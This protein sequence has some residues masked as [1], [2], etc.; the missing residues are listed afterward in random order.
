MADDDRPVLVLTA[1]EDTTADDV[2]GELNARSVPVVRLDPGDFPVGVTLAAQV[3]GD[4]GTRG[5]LRTATRTVDLSRVRAVYRRRP[6]PYRFDHLPARDAEFA[7]AQARHGLGGVLDAL[8][9]A[10]YVNHPRRNAAADYKPVQLA[11]AAELGFPVPAT[12]I[13][14][15]PRTARDFTEDHGPVVYKPLRGTSYRDDDG[16][17]LTIWTQEVNPA[18]LDDTVSG[19][20][21]LFQE[22]VRKQADVRV[23]VIGREIFA[24]RIDTGGE[25]GVLLDWRRDY[26]RHTYA[27]VSLPGHIQ[28]ALHRFLD[29]FGLLFGCFD[30]ALDTDGALWFLELNPNGQFAWL[31][32]ATGLPMAAAM[33]D[34]LR[35]GL[36]A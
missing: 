26:T 9:G 7:I 32:D 14:N 12:L 35:K 27:V 33:A 25:D 28:Q 17:P 5:T 13:T 8:P 34:L 3:G 10:L 15:D 31:A 36:P 20:A 11:A 29:R 30:F 2:I 19:T 24:V 23:T 6:G 21:H 1:L 18:D 22:R 16:M 4:A